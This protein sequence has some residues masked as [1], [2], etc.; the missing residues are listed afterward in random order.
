MSRVPGIRVVEAQERPATVLHG[1]AKIQA[2]G[3]RVT[4]MKE[5]I[6]FRRKSR[7]DG[8]VM[9]AAGNI[10]RNDLADEIFGLVVGH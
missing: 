7:Y 9:S 6:G 4:D 2:N 10:V 8:S 3:F 5:P 1:N